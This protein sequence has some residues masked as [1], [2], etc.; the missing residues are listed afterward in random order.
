MDDPGF[1]V[2]SIGMG[3]TVISGWTNAKNYIRM[4]KIAFSGRKWI[5]IIG[6]LH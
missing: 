1:P 5:Q 3:K 4:K 6:Q 2:S